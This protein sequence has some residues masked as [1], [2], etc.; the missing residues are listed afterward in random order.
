[1]T[2]VSLEKV[3]FNSSH[4]VHVHTATESPANL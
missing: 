1:M 2:L 4:S 3:F